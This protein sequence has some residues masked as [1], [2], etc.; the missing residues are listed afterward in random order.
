MAANVIIMQIKLN[1]LF[2]S[3]ITNI[4]HS[5]SNG[6]YFAIEESFSHNNKCLQCPTDQTKQF[7]NSKGHL[8]IQV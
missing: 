7:N 8:Y 2:L 5:Q 6:F 1:Y 4:K 3:N